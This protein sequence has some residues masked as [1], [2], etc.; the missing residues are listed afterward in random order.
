MRQPDVIDYDIP[1]G[2]E[3]ETFRGGPLGKRCESY[4][5][6]I[7]EECE[8][9]ET[10]KLL[11]SSGGIHLCSSHAYLIDPKQRKERHANQEMS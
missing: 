3:P 4:L 1:S 11:S 6:G 8:S 9:T 5:F 10:K 7:K 2:F